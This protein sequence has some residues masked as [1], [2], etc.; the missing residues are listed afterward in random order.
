VEIYSKSPLGL[1]FHIG[2]V[3]FWYDAFASRRSITMCPF[4]NP[5]ASVIRSLIIAGG[6]RN[7]KLSGETTAALKDF[8]F[9]FLLAPCYSL[10]GIETP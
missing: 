4:D 5:P 8:P 3:Y 2:E 1:C 9:L 6:A 7:T 10:P